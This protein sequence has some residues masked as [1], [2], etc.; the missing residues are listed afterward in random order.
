MAISTPV[1]KKFSCD[2]QFMWYQS[3]CDNFNLCDINSAMK[4][5]TLT[6]INTALTIYQ[7]SFD[8]IKIN[9]C[10]IHHQFCYG[11]FNSYQFNC[12]I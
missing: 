9:L 1:T 6:D 3:S 7:L 11:N 2:F 8:K 4:T 12:D 10:D 5:S